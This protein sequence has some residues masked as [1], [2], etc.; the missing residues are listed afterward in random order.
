MPSDAFSRELNRI[1]LARLSQALA[2]IYSECIEEQSHN[3][4]HP[5]WCEFT[6]RGFNLG[7]QGK[8]LRGQYT[9]FR[10]HALD[11]V[12]ENPLP[13]LWILK[14]QQSFNQ[15]SPTLSQRV[16]L[17]LD[18]APSI[19]RWAFRYRQYTRRI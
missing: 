2:R 7:R 11:I 13:Q 5:A 17:S 4:T 1:G 16:A 12:S 10:E 8:I 19:G 14:A 9:L 15:V 6:K 3:G 18:H